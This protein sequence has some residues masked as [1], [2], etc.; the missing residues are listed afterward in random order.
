MKGPTHLCTSKTECNKLDLTAAQYF[1]LSIIMIGPDGLLLVVPTYL[2]FHLQF[3][4]WGCQKTKAKL[5]HLIL[6]SRV[7]Y[8]APVQMHGHIDEPKAILHYQVDCNTSATT[9]WK[10]HFTAAIGQAV[11]ALE[12]WTSEPKPTCGGGTDRQD[13]RVWSFLPSF[14]R[15]IPWF[16]STNLW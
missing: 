15:V 11:R 8:W 14:A 5:R 9:Y 2:Q 4:W 1:W 13:Y 16:R 3:Y 6:L 12:S 7:T 10:G